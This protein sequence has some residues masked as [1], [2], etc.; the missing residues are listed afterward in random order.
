MTPLPVGRRRA[1]LGR[2][3]LRLGRHLL[4]LL[5]LFG[6]G[7]GFPVAFGLLVPVVILDVVVFRVGFG[8]C[9]VNLEGEISIW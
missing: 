8:L 7:L 6:L 1:G 5:V 4:R 9:C 3:L 2:Q